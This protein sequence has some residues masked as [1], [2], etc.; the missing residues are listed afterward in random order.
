MAAIAI[1]EGW[2]RPPSAAV[3]PSTVVNNAIRSHQ[4]R[5]TSVNPPRQCLLAKHQLA[6]SVNESV[7]ESALHPTAF[8]GAIRPKGTVWY[9]ATIGKTRWRNPFVGI[10]IP[11][12]PP[13]KPGQPKRMKDVRPKPAASAS[14]KKGKS[15]AAAPAPVKIRLVLGQGSGVNTSADVELEEFS[16]AGSS[17][18]RSRSTS[19]RSSMTPQSALPLAPH[20]P[21]A[22]RRI[23]NLMDSSDESD[24]S[25]SEMEL[26]GPVVTK[27]IKIRKDRPPPLPI[28]GHTTSRQFIPPLHPRSLGSPFL[29]WGT[30]V[31]PTLS[32]A[33][34]PAARDPHFP[35]HSLDNAFWADR[36]VLDPFAALETSSSSSEDEMRE[37]TEWGGSSSIL[38]RGTDGEDAKTGWTADVEETVKEATEA[39][40]VLFPM[41]LGEDDGDSDDQMHLN[42]L[43][44]RPTMSDTSS[45]AESVSTAKAT[46]GPLRSAELAANVAL[47]AWNGHASPGASPNLRSAH[48]FL[49]SVMIDSPTQHLSKLNHSFDAGDMEVEE[50]LDESGELP[51]KADDSDVEFDADLGS[52]IGDVAT[53]EHDRQLHT[54][55]WAREAAASSSFR[56]KEEVADY[57]S[58]LTTESD[59]ISAAEYRASRASSTGSHTPSS[60]LSELPPYEIDA[61]RLLRPDIEEIILGPESVSMEELDGWLPVTGKESKTPQRSRSARKNKERND[62]MRC[63]GSWGGIGV[64]SLIFGGQ[65]I[66]QIDTTKITP[67]AGTRQRSNRSTRRHPSSTR[68]PQIIRTAPDSLPT[69]PADIESV[70]TPLADEWDMEMD[71]IGPADLD[72]A[73]AEAEAREE[74]HRRACREKAEQQ[75]ALMEAYKQKVREGQMLGRSPNDVTPPEGWERASPWSEY[76]SG[77]WGSSDSMVHTPSA[78]SPMALH[79]SALSLDTPRYGS[80][81]PKALISPPLLPSAVGMMEEVMSQAEVDAAMSIPNKLTMPTAQQSSVSPTL[82]TPVA[83]A[84]APAGSVYKAIAKAPSTS[85][86]QPVPIAPASTESRLAP[87]KETALPS[88]ADGSATSKPA[89]H[90]SATTVA[91]LK[92]ALNSASGP[93]S[94]PVSRTRTPPVTAT[95]T[96]AAPR[97]IVSPVTAGASTSM[98]P[99][100]PKPQG[101]ITKRLCPGID[102]CVVDNIPVYAHIWENKGVKH[103]VLRRLD[104]DFVNANTLLLALGVPQSQIGEKLRFSTTWTSS[105]HNVSPYSRNGVLHSPGVPGVWVHFSEARELARRHMLDK[106]SPLSSILRED[107]FQLV[108]ALTHLGDLANEQFALL[109]N[110]D[111]NHTVAE[112]FGLPV[113]LTSMT[114]VGPADTQFVG[115]AHPDAGAGPNTALSASS[116][117]SK[118]TPNLT[119]LSTGPVPAPAPAATPNPTIRPTPAPVLQKGPL[120]RAAPPTPPD[121][122]PQPKRRRATMSLAGELS[123]LAKITSSAA[124]VKKPPVRATRASIAGDTPKPKV[125]K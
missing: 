105:R 65:P 78:L 51:V 57:P 49:P 60:G 86:T 113:S 54:A 108:S 12:A 18:G 64:G 59:E 19:R 36:P 95:Q 30:A 101:A 14:E 66:S 124:P 67:G 73:C 45:M 5:M 47:A 107:L 31:S 15:K 27:P 1:D 75:K 109:A 83:I 79:M 26:D 80:M 32:S 91:P 39:L 93:A 76:V 118:S 48:Q 110:I 42:R 92:P 56:L 96:T 77:P 44:N 33:L 125:S 13:R 3:A 46:T 4:K 52:N 20:R 112:S 16:E 90:P 40:R 34:L 82:S 84:P 103:T 35:S 97:K 68:T 81:D 89:G 106:T 10:E 88:P 55:A 69:T 53:P 104:T 8:A 37:P 94:A 102:A 74:R 63:S 23:R 9:L 41:S 123:P 87:K 70:P 21:T 2:L 61:E 122:C 17:N 28:S 114:A 58:P 50:W 120:V 85:G 29:D 43:D 38:I 6:G 121:G 22:T 115:K 117:H 111:S 62:P 25:D 99:P 116:G 98:A 119:S 72:A 100:P 7:L 71:A 11:K 24:T